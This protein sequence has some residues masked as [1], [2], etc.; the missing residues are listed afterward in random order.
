[1]L[2]PMTDFRLDLKETKNIEHEHK[3]FKY[4]FYYI[5]SSNENT[6]S[7]SSINIMEDAERVG[8][9]FTRNS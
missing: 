9:S 6:F 4:G 3:S 8:V 5:I 1:M 7:M 2:T